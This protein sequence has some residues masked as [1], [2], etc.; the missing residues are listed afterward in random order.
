MMVMGDWLLF[1]IGSKH[2]VVP[3]IMLLIV[4]RS[5]ARLPVLH[6]A[7][8]DVATDATVAAAVPAGHGCKAERERE[9]EE[10]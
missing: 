6:V 7:A 4:G 9:G 1:N 10:Y 5:R 2:A 8:V 3:G